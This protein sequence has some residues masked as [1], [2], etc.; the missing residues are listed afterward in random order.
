MGATAV[1]LVDDMPVCG[2]FIA[3]HSEHCPERSRQ[4]QEETAVATH[5][6][7]GPR[8]RRVGTVI[9]LVP[10]FGGLG[11]APAA[12]HPA[13]AQPDFGS[14]LV[15]LGVTTGD[16]TGDQPRVVRGRCQQVSGAQI[17]RP[18]P[19]LPGHPF[20]RQQRRRPRN[21]HHFADCGVLGTGI[22]RNDD[23]PLPS[24]IA[25][26]MS[27]EPVSPGVRI[28]VADTQVFPDRL[29]AAELCDCRPGLVRRT[30]EHRR[31]SVGPVTHGR[32]DG[33]LNGSGHAIPSLRC[34]T[35]TAGRQGWQA[36]P[37]QLPT[38]EV[39]IGQN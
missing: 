32:H 38:R 27:K 6:L 22:C 7:G 9:P 35:N 5:A 37:G 17:T 12:H 19:L 4:R 8:H 18:D 36:T 39:H 26:Q 28:L 3:A 20:R 24:L 25:R 33:F 2:K 11:A 34:V 16:I 21:Q 1:L 29:W 23:G 13:A 15:D 31:Q 14:G 30:R 10:S